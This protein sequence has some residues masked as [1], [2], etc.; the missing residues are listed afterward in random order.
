MILSGFI[1]AAESRLLE[2][3]SGTS[4]YYHLLL[5][6]ISANLGW[7]AITNF[8]PPYISSSKQPDQAIIPQ[9]EDIPTVVVEAGWTESVP[10]L[11]QDISLWLKGGAGFV[12]VVLLIK[13]TKITGKRVKAFIE[14]YNLDPTGNKR[15]LQTEVII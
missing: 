8:G 5:S 13:W 6:F 4:K 1:T 9:N 2:I 11:H 7:I 12:Q 14:V 3:Y 10:K 15:L